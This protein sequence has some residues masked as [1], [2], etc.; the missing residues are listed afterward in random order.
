VTHVPRAGHGAP[1]RVPGPPWTADTG[2]GRYRNPVLSADWSAPDV[3]RVGGDHHLV[4]SSV[5]RV[6]G[7]PVL[8]STDLVD[9]RLVGHAPDRLEPAGVFAGIFAPAGGVATGRQYALR[10]P[11]VFGPY[12]PRTR[13]GRRPG[14]RARRP[15]RRPAVA[16]PGRHR[17]VHP[18]D[19]PARLASVA[20]GSS[21]PIYPA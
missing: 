5:N 13:T 9:W 18:G 7:L 20:L 17:P 12:E 1:D 15:S 8:H 10:S 21:M 3:V 16:R 2:D 11:T 19:V 4:A 14:V 6:P